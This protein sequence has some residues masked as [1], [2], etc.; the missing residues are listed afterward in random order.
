MESISR[1]I[2]LRGAGAGSFEDHVLDKMGDAVEFA[3]FVAR[4]G[5]HPYAHGDG[6]DV[7]H[8]FGEDDEAAGQDGTAD[9]SFVFIAFIGRRSGPNLRPILDAL[10]SVGQMTTDG[11]LLTHLRRS[12]SAAG[13][14]FSAFRMRSLARAEGIRVTTVPCSAAGNGAL[15]AESGRDGRG[16]DLA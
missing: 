8:A 14:S 16:Y 3:G 2:V 7:L 12:R 4:A 15:S 5:L 10:F 13:S 6:A 1:A 11:T 9:V